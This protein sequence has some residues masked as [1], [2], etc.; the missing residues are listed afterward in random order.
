M[1]S[2]RTLLAAFPLTAAGF[3]GACSIST[4]GTTTTVTIDTAEVDAYGK[5]GVNAVATV[6]SIAAVASVLGSGT[7]A[8]IEAASAALTVALAGFDSATSGQVTFTV[9]DTSALSAAKSVMTALG[10]LLSDLKSAVTSLSGKI[11]S[12]DLSNVNTAIAAAETASSLTEA[13]L[14]LVSVSASAPKARMSR[15]EMF[16]AVGLPVPPWAG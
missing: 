12:N 4:S 15:P 2:R 16:R 11:G 3:L 10:T 5:V 1:F 8:I 7:V 9:D 14:G 6:L 13:L